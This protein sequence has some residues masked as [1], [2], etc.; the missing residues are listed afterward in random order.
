[1][2]PAKYVTEIA[3]QSTKIQSVLRP[4]GVAV[5]TTEIILNSWG[6]HG[7]YFRREELIE[8][9]IPS[10][11]LRLVGDEFCF[12]TGQATLEGMVRLPGEVERRPHLVLRRWRTYFTS[13]SLFLEKSVPPGTAAELCAPRGEEA[14]VGLPPLLRAR[15]EGTPLALSV[16][17]SARYALTCRVE[18]TGHA[19]WSRS[20]PDGFGLV[21]LGAHLYARGGVSAIL[22]YGR[23]DLLRDLKPGATDV[24]SIELV[25]P[26]EPGD[27]RVELDMVREGVTWFSSREPS[28]IAVGLTVT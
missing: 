28:S 5:L 17:R 22:D 24:L 19:S 25:A 26:S 6:R 1:M 3:C 16:P 27:Y 10:A 20:S 23:V 14:V 4:G 7:D 15:I 9:L 12:A 11:G 2:N 18:N 21:R 13:C 8:E